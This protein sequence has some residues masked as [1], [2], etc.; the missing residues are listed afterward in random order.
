[1]PFPAGTAQP[2]AWLGTGRLLLQVNAKNEDTGHFHFLSIRH[3]AGF[4][5]DPVFSP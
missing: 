5:L 3:D 2:F 1:M 4:L